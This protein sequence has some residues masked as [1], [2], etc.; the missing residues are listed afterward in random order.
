[1]YSIITIVIILIRIPFGMH[2]ILTIGLFPLDP[3][4][5]IKIDR[6]DGQTRKA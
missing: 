6:W 2:S 3:Q 5:N 1:M 4:A